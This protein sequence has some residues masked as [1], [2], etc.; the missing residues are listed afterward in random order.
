[1]EGKVVRRKGGS[2]RK[3]LSREE[4]RKMIRKLKDGK[5]MTMDKVPNEVWKY[6]G[7]DMENM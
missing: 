4:E 5:A 7:E 3:E 1:M 2:E 6:G